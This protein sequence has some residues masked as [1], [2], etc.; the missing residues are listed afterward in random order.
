MRLYIAEKPSMARAIA[1]ELGAKGKKEGYIEVRDGVVSWCVGHI[2]GQAPPDAYDPRYKEWNEK[3]LPLIPERWKLIIGKGMSGQLGVLK[4][5]IGE[6]SEI[7]NAGDPD[8]EGQ[9][10]VDE[11]L[12]HL[13]NKKP[14]R[15]LWLSSLDSKSV[16]EALSSMKSNADPVYVALRESAVARSR[17]DWL[18]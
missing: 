17:A 7:V 9:L 16:R 13:G 6:A 4:K 10:I 14:V 8:R 1:D 5:L 11:V 2:L 12:E 18:V 3:D 15:R